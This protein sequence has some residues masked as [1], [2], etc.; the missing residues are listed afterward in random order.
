MD[1][2]A[3]RTDLA[4]EGMTCAS[5]VARVERAL[6]RVP[7]VDQAE[8]N[9]ATERARVVGSAQLAALEAA[10]TQA[11]YAAHPVT[12]APPPARHDGWRVVLAA[13]LSL[14]LLAGMLAHLAGVPWMLPGWAQL[15]LATPVQFWLGARFYVAGWKAARA[16]TGNMDLLVALGSSAAFGL[17]LFDLLAG[18]DALYFE[19]AALI[20]TFIL[21]GKFLE[22]RAR[23][24]AAAAIRALGRL[25]PDTALLWRDG[26]EVP[27]PL[28]AV[29]PGDLVVVRPGGRIP[30]DGV[31]TEGSG[32]V[33]EAMLTGEAIPVEKQ[34]DASVVAGSINLD[35]RL[36]LRAT[37]VG[38]ETVL[39][40]IVRL[41]EGAQASKAPIQRLAD[42]V[43]AVFVPVVLAIALLTA[44]GWLLAGA[45]ASAAVLNAVSVLVIACPCALGLATPV[46]M[47][48]G[49]GVAARQGILIQDAAALEHAHAATVIAFD[50]TGTLTEG[51]PDLVGLFPA[52]GESAE[53]LLQAAA[54][55]QSGSEH[56]LAAALRRAV[57]GSLPAVADFRALPGRG[58]E[59][60]I[61]GRRLAMGSHRLL[62]ERGLTPD[63][64]LA[65][66]AAA[67]E[68][69]GR[70]L[71]WLMAP[72]RVLAVAA[73]GDALKPNA[74][75]AIA[76]LHQDGLRTVLLTGDRIGAARVVADRLGITDLR[77]ELLPED[78][79][80]AVA[81]LRA[82]GAVVAMVGDGINDAPALAAADIGLA[83]ATGTDVAMGVAGITLMRGD[84]LLVPA[85]I[86]ISR[87]TWSKIRQG[88]FWAFVYNLVGIP[89]AALGLLSP[90]LAGAAMAF[91]SVSVVANALLLRRWRAHQ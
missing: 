75:A 57:A 44:L 40:R 53:A 39:S 83:M 19:S 90:V 16:G 64:A 52:A 34:P 45:G 91:S 67:L 73:F 9:L 68:A 10:V 11:G 26:N 12:E 65:A 29:H 59:A 20:I 79:A 36:V 76:R 78:K 47:M 56:P 61:A 41:V 66:R 32:A 3:E 86:A 71:A 8:V 48:V 25:R 1:Q 13:V 31:V 27:V 49:T 88:L 18:R 84:P 23:G 58:V 46:A 38:S 80:A 70:T 54:A 69:E 74:A 85:A 21:F 17:S 4:I 33:D 43:S 81:A 5:C 55:L 2:V 50:K 22:V 63:P 72:D 51:R 37:A 87:R 15:A 62:Q 14:P 60:D 6:R 42:K 35:G 30:V 24:Q 7:G 77:A 89:L 28:D 82:P